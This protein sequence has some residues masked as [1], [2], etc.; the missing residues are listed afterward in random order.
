MGIEKRL[1]VLRPNS[2][3]SDVAY[4]RIRLELDVY[5]FFFE[6]KAI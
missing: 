6:K 4:D 5:Y 3:L 2:I 1:L